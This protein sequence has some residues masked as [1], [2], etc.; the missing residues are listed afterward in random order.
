ML[1]PAASKTAAKFE[2][3]CFYSQFPCS[4]DW[5]YSVNFDIAFNDVPV[6]IGWELT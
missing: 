4:A 2:R 1:E 6:R 5:L 3:H